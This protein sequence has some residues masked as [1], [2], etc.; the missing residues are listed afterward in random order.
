MREKFVNFIKNN[1]LVITYAVFAIVNELVSIAFI[2]C[3]PIIT[4][5]IYSLLIFCLA[6]SI[7]LLFK[8]PKTKAVFCI[9]FLAF[10]CAI[11]VGFVYLYDSNG[12]FFEWAMMNQR[13]DAFG[14]IEDLSLRWG[15]LAVLC[16]CIWLQVIITILTFKYFYKKDNFIYKN[17]KATKLAMALFMVVCA[18]FIV[19]NPVI[20]AT[21]DS[22]LS[23][24][25]RYLY[26]SGENKYQQMGITANAIYEFFNGT[27]VDATMD[28]SLNGVEEFIFK[29]GGGGYISTYIRLFWD[30]QR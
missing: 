17:T 1:I 6:V 10:Q 11:N 22:K 3:K 28:Y 7:L 25:D 23:Y 26:G 15:L 19:L 21:K 5:P 8:S 9:L 20:N 30:K 16:W 4:S 14:T 13:N 27:V 29:D 2:G 12:T 18:T 24:I